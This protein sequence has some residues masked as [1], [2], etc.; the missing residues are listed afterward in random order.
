VFG[1]NG[2]EG[3]KTAIESASVTVPATGPEPV[4]ANVVPVTVEAS[5]RSEKVTWIVEASW[6]LAAP[7]TGTT[8]VMVG[9]VVSPPTGGF[10]GGG[11]VTWLSSQETVRKAARTSESQRSWVRARSKIDPGRRSTINPRK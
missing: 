6:T 2:A 5:T 10:G 4:T 9:E 8:L 7:L 1:A 3:E 11:V